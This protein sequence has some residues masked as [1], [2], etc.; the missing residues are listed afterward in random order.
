M[1]STTEQAL[2][3]ADAVRAVNRATVAATRAQQG[4][5]ALPEAQVAVLHTLRAHPSVTPAEL[6][7]RLD[8]ARPTVSNLLR[9]LE[10]AG[11]VARERSASDRRSV[12]LTITER[13]RQVQDAF[14]RGRAEVLSSVWAELDQSDRSALT[15][16]TPALRRLADLLRMGDDA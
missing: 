10:A 5:P 1:S 8:L 12:L 14:H 11:L 15:A 16:A 4:L 7:Q 9:D 6:A 13:A 2:A 3:V